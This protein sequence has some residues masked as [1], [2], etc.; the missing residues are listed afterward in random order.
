[1]RLL[2]AKASSGT[3]EALRAARF[4]PLVGRTG[5]LT[6][7]HRRWEQAKDGK[8]QV[9]LLREEPGISIEG[10]RVER[11]QEALVNYAARRR[12]GEPISTA[13]VESAVGEIIA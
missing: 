6:V 7:L 8:G 3:D 10:G 9:M 1:M 5:V 12:R 13:F 2:K 4:T 11:N